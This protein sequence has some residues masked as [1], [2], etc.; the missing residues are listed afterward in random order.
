MAKARVVRLLVC[1]LDNTLYDWFSAF[2]PAF[3][4]MV[5]KAC[6]LLSVEKDQLLDELQ[7]VHRRYGDS[8]HPF[9]L[10]E[11]N[12][13]RRQ[14]PDASRAKAYLDP[15]FHAFNRERK[16]NLKAYSGVQE[17]LQSI[18]EAGTKIIAYTDARLVNGLFRLRKLALVGL[19]SQIYAPAHRDEKLSVAN[20]FEGLITLLPQD[21]RKPN[22][23]TLVDICANFSIDRT[24][25]LYVGDSLIRD[26]WMAKQAGCLAAWAKYGTS[27]DKQLW[28]KLVRVTHWTDFDVAR[29]EALRARIEHVHADIIL[30]KFSDLLTNFRFEA[31]PQLFSNR[32]NT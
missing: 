1:D 8:E 2:V 10:L 21:D 31:T 30:D 24:Q 11:T 7:A 3:Y 14:F 16:A 4:M 20:E 32:S 23:K 5:D 19:I 6:E 15:A 26:V 18:N 17:T 28:P 25:V 27:Y 12:S 22:P 13:V 29:D 9:S